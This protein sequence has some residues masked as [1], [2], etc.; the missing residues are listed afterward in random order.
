MNAGLT[1]VDQSHT[2]RSGLPA[3]AKQMYSKQ[4]SRGARP[5]CSNSQGDILSFIGPGNFA[6][7][8]K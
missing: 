4:I 8:K 2:L 1:Q 3:Y 6:H 7:G 5:Q